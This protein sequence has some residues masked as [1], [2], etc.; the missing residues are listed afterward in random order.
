MAMFSGLKPKQDSQGKHVGK[1]P[2]PPLFFRILAVICVI[3]GVAVIYYGYAVVPYKAYGAI[4]MMC[5][6]TLALSSIE[7]WTGKDFSEE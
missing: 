7:I 2:S 6:L 3:A 5:G 1:K 4:F